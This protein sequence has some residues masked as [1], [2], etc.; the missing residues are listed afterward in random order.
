MSDIF[1]YVKSFYPEV[2]ESKDKKKI[3]DRYI[4]EYQFFSTNSVLSEVDNM[5]SIL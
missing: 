1:E 2:F 3:I 5:D 4:Q